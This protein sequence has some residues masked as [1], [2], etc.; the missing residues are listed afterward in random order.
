MGN[1]AVQDLVG[2]SLVTRSQLHL[3][4]SVEL[5]SLHHGSQCRNVRNEKEVVVVLDRLVL[6]TVHHSDLFG[7]VVWDAANETT[8]IG[9]SGLVPLVHADLLA[10]PGDQ[11]IVEQVYI[12]VGLGLDDSSDPSQGELHLASVGSIGAD[13]D[14]HPHTIS[15]GARSVLSAD[16]I[17][18]TIVAKEAH[19]Q[20]FSLSF[21]GD[22]LDGVSMADILEGDSSAAIEHLMLALGITAPDPIARFK[23]LKPLVTD[24]HWDAAQSNRFDVGYIT[25]PCDTSIG[26]IDGELVMNVPPAVGPH[27][28]ALGGLVQELGESTAARRYSKRGNVDL[29]FGV[30]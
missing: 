10:V 21:L 2:F 6:L 1:F 23:E 27:Q 17:P 22:E 4:L 14:R 18:L 24:R 26:H 15:I 8:P 20:P 28:E 25:G 16:P 19:L 5:H 12:P 11:I 29:G 3:V 13:G 7:A 30:S 9:R